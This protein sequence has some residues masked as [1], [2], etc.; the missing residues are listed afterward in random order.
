MTKQ[1]NTDES[2]FIWD[3]VRYD[4]R[5]ERICEH[6]IGHTVG[7]QDTDQLSN[8]TMW[9]HGCDGCCKDYKRMEK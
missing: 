8:P 1:P 7:H 5:L 4:N 2:D 3:L 6:G 9:I